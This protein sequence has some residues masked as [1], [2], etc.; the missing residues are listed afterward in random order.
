MDLGPGWTAGA[1][2]L[3]TAAAV[4]VALTACSAPDRG[5]PA[6]GA[7]AEPNGSRLVV[8]EAGAERQDPRLELTSRVTRIAGHLSDVRRERVTRQVREV[9]ADYL[10]AAFVDGEHPFETFVP[11]LRRAARADAPVLEGGGEVVKAAAWFSV[12]APGGRAVGVTARL[13]V[14]LRADDGT[15]SSVTGRL[16][17]TKAGATWHVFGYDLARGE[18]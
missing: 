7:A 5:T 16:L 2:S 1:T 12:A 11:G 15:A 14:D 6:S 13:A 9:V 8:H 18:Q 10:Q 4:L 17:L 3:S